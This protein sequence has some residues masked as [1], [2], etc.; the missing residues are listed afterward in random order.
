MTVIS[1]C[2]W[3]DVADHSEGMVPGTIPRVGG[4]VSVPEEFAQALRH[5][6]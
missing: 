5:R 3:P 4:V 6:R 1:G 2:L